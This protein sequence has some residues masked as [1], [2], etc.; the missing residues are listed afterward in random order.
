MDWR[1]E[2]MAVIPCLDEEASV[3]PLVAAVR[4]YL[5]TVLVVDDGSRDNTGSIAERA[6][7]EV[8]RH[9]TAQGKGAA[10][11]AGWR[12]ADEVGFKWALTLDGDGQHSVEDIPAFF[13]CAERTS[14]VLV[15][16]NRMG[17]AERMPPLRRF[18]NRWMSRRLSKAAGRLLP[19][20][21]CG[22]RLMNLGALA[23]LTI[24]SRHFEIESEVL[25]SFIAT[26]QSVEFVPIRVIYHDERTKIR[27]LRDTLRWFWWWGRRRI[28]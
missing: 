17:E 13:K 27:P 26:G 6:G 24:S 28:R 21:Q 16:G 8:L 12:R 14:A 3:G 23:K 15:V 2:C 20:S 18:V 11:Q 25:M 4:R 7:A 9:E 1:A 10:L 5:P 19:D 22:F